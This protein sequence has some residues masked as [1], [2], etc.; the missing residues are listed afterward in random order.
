MNPLTRPLNVFVIICLL[1]IGG[2]YWYA[3]QQEKR[4]RDTATTYLRSTM[5]DIARWEVGPLWQH[6]SPEARE[7]VTREQLDNLLE[8]YE[9]LG[10]FEAMS[11]PQFSRISAALSAISPGNKIGYNFNA[12]FEGGEAQVTATLNIDENGNFSLYNFNLSEVTPEES[13]RQL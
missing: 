3:G 2:L 12:Y 5:A 8:R 6:L 7:V 10:D 1:I 11:E 13:S 9:P 4:Y